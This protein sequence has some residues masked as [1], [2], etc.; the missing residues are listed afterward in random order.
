MLINELSKQTGITAHTI[1]YYEKFGLIKGKQKPDVKTN[2]YFHY[3]DE[4]VYKLNLINTAKSVGF[5][6]AE[7]KVLL[8]SWYNKKITK[9]RKVE[10]LDEKII[11]INLK[12]KELKNMKKLIDVLKR[13][14]INEICE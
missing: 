13:D 12:I 2:K 6:L 9:K 1:R 7:I 11:A 8:D 5:T 14:V 4:T 3:D 10:I